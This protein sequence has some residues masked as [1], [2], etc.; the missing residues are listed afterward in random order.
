[1]GRSTIRALLQRED[2]SGALEVLRGTIQEY[3]IHGLEGIKA[4]QHIGKVS[5]WGF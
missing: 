1:V 4:M 2:H 5:E 3:Q